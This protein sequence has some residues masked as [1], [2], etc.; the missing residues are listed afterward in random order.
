MEVLDLYDDLGNKLNETIIRGEKIPE[1]KNIML[2]VAFIRNSKGEYLIQKTSPEKDSKYTST[3]GHVTHSEDGLTTIIRELEEEISL[4]NVED[5]IEHLKTFKYPTKP[6]VFNVYLLKNTN[7]DI[8]KLK[9]QP[10]EVEQVMWLNTDKINSLI[11]QGL[12][13][14]SHAYIFNNYIMKE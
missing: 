13:L 3:G 1:G 9:L 2:S 8:S 5:K 11:K 7:I 4:T 6:A 10:E 12:F 14:E